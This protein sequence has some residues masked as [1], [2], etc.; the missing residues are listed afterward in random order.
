MPGS[1]QSSRIRSG[2]LFD[3]R[4]AG[5]A[6]VAGVQ[7]FVL[8]TAQ[9]KGDHVADRGFVFNDQDALLHA[10]FLRVWQDSRQ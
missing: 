1:I 3:D 10:A 8:G 2:T 4:G 6:R 9:R 7:G 5:F